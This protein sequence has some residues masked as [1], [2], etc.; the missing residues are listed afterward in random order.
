MRNIVVTIKIIC[1]ILILLLIGRIS[2]N[3]F[4]VDSVNIV[5]VDVL[6]PEKTPIF[7]NVMC[8]IF[9]TLY[10]MAEYIM[11]LTMYFA[12][13]FLKKSLAFFGIVLE[14]SP[15]PFIGVITILFL[16][17]ILWYIWK[18]ESLLDI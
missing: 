14:K 3:F 17:S 6:L 7:V 5:P 4:N 8:R 12:G 2:L 13:I 9:L 10:N 11:W 16:L 15:Y 18:D 1:T